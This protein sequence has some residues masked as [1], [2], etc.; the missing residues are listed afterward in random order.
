MRKFKIKALEDIPLSWERHTTSFNI[1]KGKCYLF[2]EIRAGR[3]DE[4]KLTY[5]AK[6]RY[7]VSRDS[8]PGFDT[9]KGSLFMN[10][11]ELWELLQQKKIE[12]ISTT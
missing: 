7:Y 1:P 9:P 10:D 12:I 2:M 6:R 8:F 11:N 5:G 3:V 4:A